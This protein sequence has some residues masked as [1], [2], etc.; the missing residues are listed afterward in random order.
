LRKCYKFTQLYFG[1][2]QAGD[3]SPVPKQW[4]GATQVFPSDAL[5]DMAR[6]S[7]AQI[8][9]VVVHVIAIAGHDGDL[10]VDDIQLEPIPL[11]INH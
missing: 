10:F 7:L 9:F 2:E 3:L 4:T 8:Q 11:T 5:T 1:S 6:R